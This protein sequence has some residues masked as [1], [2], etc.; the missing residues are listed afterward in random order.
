MWDHTAPKGLTANNMKHGTGMRDDDRIGILFDTFNAHRTG[1]RFDTNPN[2]VRHD[3]LANSGSNNPDWTV[4]WEVATSV[5]QGYWIAEFAIPFKSLPF[6]PHS[7]TWGLN[8]NRAIRRLGEESVWVA[9]DRD[10]AVGVAGDMNGM[11]GMQQGL[12]LDVV[13]G[14]T[15]GTR[16]DRLVG[17]RNTKLSPSLDAYYRLTHSLNASLTFN[18]DFSATEVDDRQVNLSRFGLF[19]PEKRDFFLNDAEQFEFGRFGGSSNNSAN[20][21]GGNT[22]ISR[23]GQENGRPFFSRR[24]GLGPDG[25]PLD[26]E[27]GAKLSG[28]AGRWNIGALAIQ[29]DDYTP[30]NGP[31]Q[32]TPL[33][34]VARLSAN[35]LSESTL[36]GIFTSGSTTSAI[37]NSVLGL[38]FNYRNSHVHGNHTVLGGL[39]A[40]QSHSS[41]ARGR[42]LAYGGSIGMPSATGW[43]GELSLRELQE[44]FN[45]A[46]G[47]VNVRGVRQYALDVGHTHYTRGGLVHS[48]YSGVDFYRLD[49]LVRGGLLSQLVNTRLFKLSSKR[50]D[51]VE[52]VWSAQQEN[53]YAPFTLYTDSTRRVFVPAGL[54]RFGD[55]SVQLNAGRARRVSGG[56]TLASGS[57]YD[58]THTAV[59]AKFTL[60]QSRHFSVSADADWDRIRLPSGMFIS[61]LV[62]LSTEVGFTTRLGWSSSVQYDNSSE[63]VGLQS[64][65]YYLPKAGQKYSLV[66][67]HS[68]QD[69]DRDRRFE[70]TVS[71]FSVRASYTLRF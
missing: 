58:G 71:E 26:I 21:T 39:W 54:H 68:M 61:R 59:N 51:S 20:S 62:R 40:Q 48:W 36:G 11:S 65:L 55:V 22:A 17:K 30:P 64:R 43:R 37:D 6:D 23:A 69:P 28:R 45:P 10:W 57:F 3:V 19:F 27:Y 46:L 14:A 53:V 25:S 31:V 9:H 24:L 44:N 70:P 5:H 4:I 52:V 42:D 7:E 38:D 29:Q 34:L 15:L 18:T 66:L 12:G 32:S 13:P 1:Y 50:D 60:K 2:G 49:D 56:L 33:T 47:Y 63:L 8:V 67:N 16:N 41:N 35:V